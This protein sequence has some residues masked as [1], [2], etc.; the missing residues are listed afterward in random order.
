MKPEV[1]R[2]AVVFN[3]SPLF[4]GEAG[5][6][7]SEIRKWIIENDWLDAIVG[8]PDQLFYNT[9]L[10]TYIWLVTNRKPAARKGKV[11]LINAVT[12]SQKA[13]RSLGAKRN[14]LAPAR[15]DQ[16]VEIYGRFR[17]GT[18]SV[19][20][21]NEELGYQRI[22]VERPLRLTFQASHE[23]LKT[24]RLTPALTKALHQ[25]AS[26]AIYRS[27]ADFD[28]ALADACRTAG[29]K[30]GRTLARKAREVLARSDDTAEIC[31]DAEGRPLADPD[32]RDYEN[33]PLNENLEAWFLREVAPHAPDAWIEHSKTRCGYAIPFT[34]FFFEPERQRPLEEIERDIV[35]IEQQ[36]RNMMRSFTVA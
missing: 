3:G 2:I 10:F 26:D 23:R 4:A 8:L 33:V 14:E 15:I 6:G 9:R 31:R 36:I 25:M 13:Q 35:G 12:F 7:E 24:A 30:P 5:S 28:R 20:L 17:A 27:A 21:R 16:I 29:I 34:R 22:T 11:Q 18:H 19:I 32:L 1:S